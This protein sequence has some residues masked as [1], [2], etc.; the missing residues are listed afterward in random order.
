[1]EKTERP[2]SLGVVVERKQNSS[3]GHMEFQRPNTS[4]WSCQ[5]GSVVRGE[6]QGS[7]ANRIYRHV[8]VI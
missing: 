1:M 2:M 6:Q 3:S 7:K 8:V 5:G 4:E